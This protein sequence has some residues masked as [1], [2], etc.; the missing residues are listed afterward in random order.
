MYDKEE[1]QTLRIHL[2][3]TVN[4]GGYDYSLEKFTLPIPMEAITSNI[5]NDICLICL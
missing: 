2:Q 5:K 1:L 3:D 4:S